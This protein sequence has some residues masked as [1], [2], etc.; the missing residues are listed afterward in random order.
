MKK[1]ILLSM[2]LCISVVLQAQ[3]SKTLTNLT[4]GGLITQM[5]SAELT[6]I[7]NLTL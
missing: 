3:V 6:T 7:T 1:A 5:T 2:V 4:P